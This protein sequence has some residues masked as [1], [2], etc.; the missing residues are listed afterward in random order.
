MTA[1]RE[2][3]ALQIWQW[4]QWQLEPDVRAEAMQELVGDPPVPTDPALAAG[5]AELLLPTTTRARR[6]TLLR[7]L[8][9]ILKDAGLSGLNTQR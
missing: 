1:Q 4:L 3:E 5:F 2:L 6:V 8:L 7:S 9:R